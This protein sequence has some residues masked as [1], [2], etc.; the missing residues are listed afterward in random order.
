M[1]ACGA[2]SR[3][4][5]ARLRQFTVVRVLVDPVEQLFATWLFALGRWDVR[6][7][8]HREDTASN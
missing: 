3:Q 4:A 5:A 1:E 6:F 2:V 7:A 8:D